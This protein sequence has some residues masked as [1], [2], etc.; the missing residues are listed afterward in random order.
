MNSKS[1]PQE[2]PL[3]NIQIKADEKDMIG[4]YANLAQI[5]HRPEEF[6]LCFYYIFSNIPQGKLLHT[7]ILSPAH[8]KRFMRALQENIERYEQAFGPIQ[9]EP[10]IG[11]TNIGFVQ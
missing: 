8:A 10:P 5:T 7:T 6:T 9:E 11:E 1:G 3:S 2:N 4:S